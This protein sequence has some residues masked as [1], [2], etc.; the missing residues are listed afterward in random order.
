MP[1]VSSSIRSAAGWVQSTNAPV[2]K[3][4]KNGERPDSAAIVRT[5]VIRDAQA[6]LVRFVGCDF[7][8]ADNAVIESA[9]EAGIN[10]RQATAFMTRGPISVAL[11]IKCVGSGAVWITSA[12]RAE[13]PGRSNPEKEK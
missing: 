9:T 12:V 4:V 2:A 8:S 3:L 7:Y 10:R 5:Q 13:R 6:R 1:G 11:R